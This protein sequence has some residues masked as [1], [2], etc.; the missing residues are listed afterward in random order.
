[1][2]LPNQAQKAA[3]H[4]PSPNSASTPSSDFNLKGLV[5]RLSQTVENDEFGRVTKPI[6][7]ER[8]RLMI[9]NGCEFRLGG[10]HWNLHS[11]SLIAHFQ[12]C[13]AYFSSMERL[14]EKESE[15]KGQEW[16]QPSVE[17]YDKFI[18]C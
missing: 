13:D 18:K 9:L 4:F 5:D 17:S 10:I 14:R 1:M 11:P 6:V 15:K 8:S 3:L 7:M 12:T 16:L 2:F